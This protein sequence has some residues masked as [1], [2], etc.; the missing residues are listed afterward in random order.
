MSSEKFKEEQKAADLKRRITE[1]LREVRALEEEIGAELR[2]LRRVRRNLKDLIAQLRAKKKELRSVFM[3]KDFKKIDE[4]IS[5]IES[6]MGAHEKEVDVALKRDIIRA[7]EEAEKRAEDAEKKAEE[8]EKRA[9]DAEKKAE[10]AEKRVRA[11]EEIAFEAMRN[12][13]EAE[14]RAEEC[15]RQLK[16]LRADFENFKKRVERDKKEFADYVIS[17]FA[18]SLITVVD[19]LE[20]AI[21]H[22]HLIAAGASQTSQQSA[23]S[24]VEPLL[25]GV[26]MTLNRIKELMRSE[27]IEEMN[28]KKG[29]KFDPFRHEVVARE[30]SD[31][32]EG[33]ILEVLRK[34]Y[35]YRGK[36]LRPAA[37]KTAAK[38]SDAGDV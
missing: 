28:V 25:K 20:R 19:D 38:K 4:W 18:T 3:E 9:E 33:T 35:V 26:E 2:N 24:A 15:V 16:Y 37:V 27:G 32:P 8:A 12:K 23:E 13:E 21:E 11:A 6:E 36:I 14:K 5:M 10:E 30:E 22:A 17:N 29:D 7:A 34:G 1:L 31:E